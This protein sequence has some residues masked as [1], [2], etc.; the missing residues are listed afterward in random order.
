MEIKENI[1]KKEQDKFFSFVERL[2]YNK[3][4]S[5]FIYTVICATGITYIKL[6]GVRLYVLFLCFRQ[7]FH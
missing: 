4:M 6:G 5:I 7:V 3:N 1:K 2:L